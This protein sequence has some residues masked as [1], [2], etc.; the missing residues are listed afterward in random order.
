MR[1]GCCCP[2]RI[3]IRRACAIRCPGSF[4][5]AKKG[6]GRSRGMVAQKWPSLLIKSERGLNRVSKH[7]KSPRNGPFRD[8]MGAYQ[9]RFGTSSGIVNRLGG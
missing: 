8:L 9:G 3:T 5:L 2:L 4:S 7:L 1:V 6:P